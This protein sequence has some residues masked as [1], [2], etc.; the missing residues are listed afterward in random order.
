MRLLGKVA[1]LCACAALCVLV[2]SSPRLQSLLPPGSAGFLRGGAEP[3]HH[4]DAAAL[5]A[6][7]Q[8]D[9]AEAELS[10]RHR[11][12]PRPAYCRHDRR[13]RDVA[14]PPHAD[15]AAAAAEGDVV[16]RCSSVLVLLLLTLLLG[17]TRAS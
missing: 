16:R 15:G 1:C 13:V 17:R 11:L 7:R 6:A 12:P 8:R 3:P 9:R 5:A 2:L 14:R 10:Q 4:L